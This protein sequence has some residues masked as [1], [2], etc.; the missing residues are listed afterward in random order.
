MAK[1][2]IHR[3]KRSLPPQYQ[4]LL[5]LLDSCTSIKKAR[6][7]QSQLFITGLHHDSLFLSKLLPYFSIPIQNPS[8]LLHDPSTFNYNTLIRAFARSSSP[9]NSV[10]LYKSMLSEGPTRPNNFTFPFL[11]VSCSKLPGPET[12]LQVHS[13]VMKLGFDLDSHVRHSLIGL[14]CIFGDLDVARYLFD[15]ITR[16]DVVS[17]NV[18]M[19]GYNKCGQWDD[20]LRVFGYMLRVGVRPDD[21]TF[22]CLMSI[23]SGLGDLTRGK[24]VHMLAL[25]SFGSDD[26]GNGVKLA[27][28]NMYSKLGA[29]KMADRVFGSMGS[30]KSVASW[31][32]MVSGYAKCGKIENARMVF[33]EMPKKDLISWTSMISGYSQNGRYKEAVELYEEMG[34]QGVKPDEVTLVAVLSACAHLGY[35]DFGKRI[36]LYIESD[37][38][39]CNNSRLCTA[40]VDM[41]AKCGHIMTALEI[42]NRVD[43]KTK[44]SH[45][46]NSVISGLAQHGL[47][48]RAI[49]VFEEMEAL[50]LSP[51]KVTFVG[52]LCACSHSGLIEKGKE[53]FDM[54]VN[55]YSIQPQIEHYCCMVDLLGR[56][57][58]INEAYDFI[59]NMPISPNSAIWSALLRNCRIHRNP[60]IGEIAQRKLLHFVSDGNSFEGRYSRL[61]EMFSDVK[62]LENAKK[63][64]KMI[65]YKPVWKQ[66]GS[67]YVDF[68][69]SLHQFLANGTSHPQSK[70]IYKML[71]E[72]TRRLRLASYD[73]STKEVLLDIE[74][75]EKGNVVS[76]HS[77]RLALAYGLMNL[78]RSETIRI[79]MDLR[80]C[81]DCHSLFKIFSEVFSREIV[82]R[83]KIIFH[84][85][86]NGLCSC[87][88]CW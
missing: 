48:E 34:K 65:K 17:F 3:A 71:D 59:Q 72:M 52:V 40:V 12:G 28:L 36:H 44:T 56:R 18:M 75:E 38:I 81:I 21:R 47:G 20:A 80:M 77:E 69:G 6:Q 19:S 70:E 25:K 26:L 29:M 87:M 14:Y 33:D 1:P 2:Q 4:S 63:V 46:F 86:K 66:Q 88:D 58:Y 61:I 60:R 57:G 7:I 45:L 31:S 35:L 68:N 5:F 53:I 23:C 84:H 55:K 79:I 64:R 10:S 85:M 13:H 43:K 30:S 37:S 82:V 15:E 9:S 27:L 49:A 76:G 11:L 54:M 73:P 67:S 51:D 50:G 83:D 16:W 42:F 39:G 62:V 74:N 8:S 32:C 78:G 22:G 24:V 41:Y